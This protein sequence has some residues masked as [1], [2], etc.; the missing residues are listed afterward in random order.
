MVRKKDNFIKLLLYLK[1]CFLV[2]FMSFYVPENDLGI[3]KHCK[4]LV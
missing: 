1:W 3:K 2:I 4:C